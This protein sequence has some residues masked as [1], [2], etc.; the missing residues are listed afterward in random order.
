MPA[1]L[2]SSFDRA[3]QLFAREYRPGVYLRISRSEVDERVSHG[4]T[5]L[6]SQLGGLVHTT[7]SALLHHCDPSNLELNYL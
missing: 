7:Y 4:V 2:S 3:V 6:H 5:L 1:H